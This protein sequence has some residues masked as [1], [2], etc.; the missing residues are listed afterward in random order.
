M[1]LDY[2]DAATA[3]PGPFAGIRLTVFGRKP[4]CAPL[5]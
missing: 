5:S 3:P 1:E 2:P 4:D